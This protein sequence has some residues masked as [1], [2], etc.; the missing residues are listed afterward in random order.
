MDRAI[1]YSQ[2]PF[3]LYLWFTDS[4]VGSQEGGAALYPSAITS[5]NSV[6][7]GTNGVS[8]VTARD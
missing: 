4:S 7:E 5:R 1:Q 8:R 3:S 2:Y 6:S